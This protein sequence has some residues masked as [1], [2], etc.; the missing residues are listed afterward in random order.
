MDSQYTSMVNF[1]P[2]GMCHSSEKKGRFITWTQ[3]AHQIQSV[4][5]SYELNRLSTA[6][7]TVV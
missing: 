3:A 6:D 1:G 5:K 2:T 4:E 7:I